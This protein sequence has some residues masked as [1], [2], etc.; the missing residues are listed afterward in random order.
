MKKY[1]LLSVFAMTSLLGFSQSKTWTNDPAHSRLGFVVKH[2]TISEING[3]FADFTVKVTTSRAD[4]SDA[5]IELVAKTTSID[6]DIDA[7]DAHLRSA[8]FFDVENYPEL[9]FKSSSL[10]KVD[11]S[12]GK[13]NGELTFHGVSKPVSLDVVYFGSVTN[14]M[15]NQETAGFKITGVI[16]RSDFNLGSNFPDAIV[17]DDIKIVANVEFSPSK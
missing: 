3:R 14:P 16:K 7:R 6:T 8:D 15:N 5:Q 12:H 11:A 9:V 4:Y 10:T 2:L 1:L 17:G 13:L